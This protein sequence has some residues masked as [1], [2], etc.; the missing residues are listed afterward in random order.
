M[1]HSGRPLVVRGMAAQ[2]TATVRAMR[3]PVTHPAMG[4]T[5]L[6]CKEETWG[7]EHWTRS[8]GHRTPPLAQGAMRSGARLAGMCN[9]PVL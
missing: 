2:G 5:A 6:E 7:S 4:W 1:G 3:E 8:G 9:L